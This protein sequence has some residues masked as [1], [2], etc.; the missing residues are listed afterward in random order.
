[1]ERDLLID[2]LA[3]CIGVTVITLVPA[4]WGWTRDKLRTRRAR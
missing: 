2:V 4:V 1:M 3:V